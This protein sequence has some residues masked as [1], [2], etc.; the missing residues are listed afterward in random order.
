[1]DLSN[2]IS[3]FA[4]EADLSSIQ[5][6]GSGHINDTYYIKAKDSSA[7]DYLLQRINNKVFKDVPALMNN[8]RL[9]IFHMRNK[10]QNVPGTNLDKEVLYLIPTHYQAYYYEDNEG[11]YWRM[12]KFIADTRSIDVAETRTQAYEGGIAIGRFQALLSDLDIKLLAYTIPRFHDIEL[13]LEQF[14]D[15][16]A[17]D[18]S[19]R[20]NEVLEE[21]TFALKR[22][23]RFSGIFKVWK[24][25]QLPLRITHNDTKLNNI[26]FDENNKPQC[27]IDLDT[28][29]PGYVANDFGDAIRTIINS[30]AEDEAQ[31]DNIQLNMEL[32]EAF[33]EGYL[34]ESQVFLNEDEIDS[35]PLSV[36]LF[37]YMQGIRFLTDYLNGDI[38]YKTAFPGHNLQRAR[39]Q[40]ELLRK[41]ELQ[42]AKIENTIFR[43]GN[44]LRVSTIQA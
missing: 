13:R 36:M 19:G 6:Y 29:M 8:I 43:L 42:Y 44:Q 40:F 1:M 7:T 41:I 21:V 11:N 26:L 35:L 28:V 15:S 38:Y 12:Y 2:I 31:L 3:K 5:P 37:P 24:D 39:A 16:L 20:K 14:R 23:E 30:A 4:A 32:F 34:K 22:A 25:K 9:V 10:L 27:I 17:S 18:A 33:T